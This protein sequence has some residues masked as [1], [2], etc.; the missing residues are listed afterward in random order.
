MGA[1]KLSPVHY[2]KL[3]IEGRHN[4]SAACGK[5]FR[6]ILFDEHTLQSPPEIVMGEDMLMNI[7]LSFAS[8]KPV[9]LVGGDSIYNYMQHGTNI[10]HISNLA[11]IMN[12]FPSGTIT[13]YS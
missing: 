12:I 7:R 11:L 13:G 10:T 3:L 2:R 1:K 5:L 6:R 8:A 9:I 4:I